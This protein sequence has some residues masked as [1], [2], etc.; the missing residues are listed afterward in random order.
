LIITLQNKYLIDKESEGFA[1]LRQI[2]PKISD[3]N[4]KEGIFDC[5][6]R[7]LETYAETF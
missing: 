2:F 1:Y 4:M 5:P 6:G 3:A 7:R